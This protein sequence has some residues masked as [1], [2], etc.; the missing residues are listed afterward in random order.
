MSILG[1]TTPKGQILDERV[2]NLVLRKYNFFGTFQFC[3]FPYKS[4]AKIFSFAYRPYCFFIFFPFLH[5]RLRVSLGIP[6]PEE[7]PLEEA[8]PDEVGE[9]EYR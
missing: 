8:I 3:H 7:P 9:K 6:E 1:L 5:R 4:V 2:E